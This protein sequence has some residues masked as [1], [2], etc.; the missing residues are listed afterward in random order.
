MSRRLRWSAVPFRAR[1]A[2]AAAG[3]LGL[4]AVA[5]RA[6]VSLRTAVLDAGG[7]RVTGGGGIVLDASLGDVGGLSFQD[8]AMLKDGYAGQLYD[9]TG[10]SVTANPTNVPE[11]GTRQLAAGAGYDDGTAGPIDG[12]PSWSVVAGPLSG[13]NGSGLATAG[14]VHRDTSATARATMGVLTGCVALLVLNVNPDNYGL[15]AA[16]GVPDD[17]QVDWFGEENPNGLAGADPDD[18]TVPNGG[19]YAGDTSPNDDSSYL[20]LTAVTPGGA[21]A[22]RVA[23]QGGQMS[24]QY[25]ERTISLTA[26]DWRAVH[27]NLPPTSIAADWLDVGADDAAAFYRLRARR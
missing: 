7:G 23:W 11:G 5:V 26:P 8:A 18:D 9:L 16:D 15:Y 12:T 13:V 21:S 19:E 4:A 24:T 20:R 22:V 3:L 6:E 27:T 25:I 14:A 17:W 2:V 1:G 10:L